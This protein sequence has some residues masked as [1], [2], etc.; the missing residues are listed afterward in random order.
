L[1]PADR[2]GQRS[3]K[4]RIK[5]PPIQTDSF[6]FVDATDQQANPDCEQLHVRQRYANVSRNDKSFVEHSIKNVEQISCSG[7]GRHSLHEKYGK[8]RRECGESAR[9]LLS[10]ILFSPVKPVNP[11]RF[12]QLQPSSNLFPEGA[13]YLFCPMQAAAARVGCA[14]K[15][16]K[17]PPRDY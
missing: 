12:K 11:C 1:R 10:R 13:Q 3:G 8:D 2:R 15:N 16:P 7:N 5:F 9:D 14:S 17:P 6:R 4:I